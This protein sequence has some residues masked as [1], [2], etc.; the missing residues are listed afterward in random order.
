MANTGDH[1]KHLPAENHD[2]TKGK[3]L[4]WSLWD[5][6]S[7]AF[8]AVATTFVFTVYLTTKDLFAPGNQATTDLSIGLAFAGLVIALV[9]PVSGQRADHKG[10]GTRMLALFSALVTVCMALMFAVYPTSPLGKTGALWLGVALL[11][12]GNIFFEF[13]SVNYNAML[14]RVSTKEN[15]GKV[16]GIG[17]GMGYLGG[18]I[19]LGVLYVGF[20]SPEVGWF[21]VTGENFLNIRIAM[22]FA[23]IWFAVFS[24]PVIVALPGRR[25]G[26]D[27]KL[28]PVTMAGVDSQD[29]E[30]IGG[31]A[32]VK[33]AYIE[34]WETI[35]R[36]A[37]TAP[38]ILRFLIASAIFRDGL[39]GVFTYGAILAS[40]VFGLSGGQVMI[41][42]IVANVVAG[43]A[44][45]ACG[46]ADDFFG[47]K[48]VMIF[49]LGCMTTLGLILFFAHNGGAKI[50]WSFGLLLCIFV[51]PV[52]SAS[53]S[54]LARIIPKGRE[55]E[56]FGL[57]ATTGRAVSFMSP[58]L[59]AL[60]VWIGKL[61]VPAGTSSQYFGVLGITLLLGVGFALL[62]PLKAPERPQK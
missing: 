32:G 49:S 5:W 50:F 38:E 1:Q 26:L 25:R 13:A 57:Y 39:A 10:R 54:F 35:K 45:I 9:A 53:R 20:I 37:K 7:A 62:A 4:A 47:P 41:F 30:P 18:I 52:Q 36:L 33:A 43:I 3:I 40:T 12:F 56:L 16:S 17:W 8:N 42:A 46:V 55:G 6:G 28:H 15:M 48:K 19:L 24:I 11:S 21:G 44:T 14:A 2:R 22:V 59:F 61:F 23:T 51:G 27:G 60:F 58:T 34:L 29:Q 31:L